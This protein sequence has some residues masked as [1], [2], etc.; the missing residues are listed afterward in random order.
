LTERVSATEHDMNNRKEICQSTGTNLHVLQIWWTL[1][2]KRLR[3]IGEFLPIPKFLLGRYCQLYGMDVIQQT[4]GKLW[5]D[6]LKLDFAMHLVI[7]I[8]IIIIR[9]LV[10]TV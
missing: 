5:H 9:W 4:A 6:G 1:V 2:Q 3:T 10:I 7:I 8:I